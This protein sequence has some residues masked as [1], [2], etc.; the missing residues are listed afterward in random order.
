LDEVQCWR[1]DH[2]LDSRIDVRGVEERDESELIGAGAWVHFEVS[3]DEEFSSHGW[4]V[5]AAL[6]VVSGQA[7]KLRSD[8]EREETAES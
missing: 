7:V 1:G 3:T 6:M 8:E 4:L 2:G 5:D